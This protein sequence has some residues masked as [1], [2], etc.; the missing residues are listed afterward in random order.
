METT[1]STSDEDLIKKVYCLT[2]A[3][4][5]LK[6]K[7]KAELVM[8]CLDQALQK[9]E[10]NEVDIICME[11]FDDVHKRLQSEGQYSDIPQ[12][13][14]DRVLELYIA[15]RSVTEPSGGAQA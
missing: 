13:I 12:A 1:E 7:R 14:E 5:L 4:S 9:L 2:A 3:C 6:D 15:R 10:D 11:F 8:A